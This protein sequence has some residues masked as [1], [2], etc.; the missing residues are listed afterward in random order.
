MNKSDDHRIS[1]VFGLI[2][3]AAMMIEA[4]QPDLILEDWNRQETMMPFTD[5][6]AYQRLLGAR[7]D[8]RRKKEIIQAAAVFHREWNRIKAEAL[9]ADANNRD[10]SER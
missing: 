10:F 1:V 8:M 7:D 9:A 5:P 4:V 3:S 2:R 6:T